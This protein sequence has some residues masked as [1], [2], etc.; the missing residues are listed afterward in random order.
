MGVDISH[1]I[2]HNFHELGNRLATEQFVKGTIGRLKKN[3]QIRP[4]YDLWEY[5][6]DEDEIMFKLPV[7]D[8]EFY[9]HDGFW[10]IE[11]YYHYCQIVMH[12]GDY[13]WLRRMTFDIARALGQE[14]AWYAEEF[15]T[16]NGGGCDVPDISFKD[17]LDSAE[18]GY[19]KPIPEFDQKAILAQG[20]V[21]IP[22]YEPIYHDSFKECKEQYELLQSKISDYKLLGL[23]HVGNGFLRCEKNGLV[24]LINEETF[25]KMAVEPFESM[26]C[27][28]NGPEFILRKNGLSAV[29][30]EEGNQLTDYVKGTFNWKWA[31]WNP[32]KDCDDYNKR[33]IYN[34]EAG[35]ELP[36]R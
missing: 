27:N 16:W 26:L 28:L 5:N 20:N 3:L 32:S 34:E 10:Q 8:V 19:G 23:S 21:G 12:Q 7:Y 14:E 22:K 13:F 29:F 2:K 36:P 33:I 17:W 9:L 4:E 31:P 35:I 11:S 18:K 1:I 6:Y 15:Y 25:K 30:D 24:F